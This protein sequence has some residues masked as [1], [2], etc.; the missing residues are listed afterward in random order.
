MA[1]GCVTSTCARTPEALNRTSA[2]AAPAIIR[3]TLIG[4]WVSS[5]QYEVDTESAKG[6][7][8]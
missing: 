7:K 2:P 5:P 1:L 8:S 3:L 6:G 4:S